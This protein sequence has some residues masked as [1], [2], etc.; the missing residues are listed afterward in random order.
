MNGEGGGAD[1]IIL[2]V[3]IIINMHLL[4]Y[5]AVTEDN[6]AD[7]RSDMIK[8]G[9]FMPPHNN[10]RKNH[11]TFSLFSSPLTSADATTYICPRASYP[12]ALSTRIA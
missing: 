9:V 1:E 10:S 7:P 8:E 2:I 5:T 6:S 11:R 4:G 12:A 3:I